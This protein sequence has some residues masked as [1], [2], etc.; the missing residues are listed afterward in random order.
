[1]NNHGKL[2]ERQLDS[3]SL[4]SEN[5]MTLS[6]V[7]TKE[8]IIDGLR[9]KLQYNPNRI[10]SSTASISKSAIQQRPCFL[11][12]K[13]RPPEQEVLIFKTESKILNDVTD[14]NGTAI[15]ARRFTILV[16]PFPVFPKHF[17]ITGDHTQQSIKGNFGVMLEMARQLYDCVV[18]YNGPKCGASAPDHMHFQAGSKGIM[19]VEV[20]YSDWKETRT[21]VL[22]NQED[23]KLFIL[24]DFLREGWLLEGKD[25]TIIEPLF[26]KLFEKIE[27]FLGN[28]DEEPMLNLLCWYENGKWI[29]LIF[30]R[31]VHRPSCYFRLDETK[32]LI[33]PASV[34]MGGLLVAARPEDFARIE[35]EDIKQIFSEVSLPE[36]EILMISEQVMELVK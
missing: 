29:T 1:M 14:E 30:P 7:L 28:T 33:S 16:N 32:Y 17:T 6:K 20:D 12:K 15:S 36:S 11:C 4:A 22:I 35:A 31:K 26:L 25:R 21:S 27:T 34:E 2:F 24:H 3:W 18:F 19:P 9:I 23:L 8:F 13:N 10:T 5:Y